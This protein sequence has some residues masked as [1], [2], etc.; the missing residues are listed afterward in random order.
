MGIG[1]FLGASGLS[2]RLPMGA[3]FLSASEIDWNLGLIYGCSFV[4]HC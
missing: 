2:I 3:L 4:S 1:E